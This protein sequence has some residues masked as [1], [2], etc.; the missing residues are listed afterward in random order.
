L[1]RARAVVTA[2]QLQAARAL[3][4]MMT[5]P[6]QRW[7]PALRRAVIKARPEFFAWSVEQRERYAVDVPK[8]DR[9]RLN[10]ALLAELFGRH[11]AN[12]ADATA[13]ADDLALD[14]QNIWNETWLPLYGIGEDCFFLNESFA[15]GSSLLDFETLRDFDEADHRFQECARHED[16]QRRGEDYSP[17]PYRG[18][19]YLSWARLFVDGRFTYAT[20]TMAAGYAYANNAAEELIE[21]RI[22]HRLVP[23]K[24]HGKV[25]GGGWQWDLRSEANGREGVLAEL[26]RRVWAYQSARSDALQAAYDTSDVGGV[27]LLDEAEPSEANLHVVITNVAALSAV[28]FRSFLRDCRAIERPPSELFQVL[29]KE[30]AALADFVEEQHAEITRTYNP[31]VSRLVRRPKIRVMKGVFDP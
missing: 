14:A 4:S 18:S 2:R 31:K 27:Y 11:Y 5:L 22:P 20:L 3:G 9:A 29:E 19:L 16:A 24:N 12:P 13:A 8:E 17:R 23:G 21:Q 7:S 25:D 30:R 28:R 1:A 6:F 15:D 10:V 26:Q